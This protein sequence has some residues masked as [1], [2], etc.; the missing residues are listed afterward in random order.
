MCT[1]HK[2]KQPRSRGWQLSV[3]VVRNT[4]QE[5]GQSGTTVGPAHRHQL[6][7]CK[8]Q[9]LRATQHCTTLVTK[10]SYLIPPPPPPPLFVF[11]SCPCS[12]LIWGFAPVS[13]HSISDVL[14]LLLIVNLR[15][16]LARCIPICAY[17]ST[18]LSSVAELRDCATFV[19]M[20]PSCEAPCQAACSS[21][22][23]QGWHWSKSCSKSRT[24]GVCGEAL[25][26]KLLIVHWCARDNSTA[27][28]LREGAI[29]PH[30]CIQQA[31]RL[32]ACCT[33]V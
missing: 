26:H 10:C 27:N 23:W 20:Q 30:D 25:P 7:A 11:C 5:Q 22:A 24:C 9:R 15:N 32:S 14:P 18:P 29:D 2:H 19:T 3:K 6:E 16:H 12:Q 1:H 17:T 31:E 4:R 8:V 33:P 28:F 13:D 21:R